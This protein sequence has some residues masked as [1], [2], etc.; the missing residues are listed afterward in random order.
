MSI[1]R[2]SLLGLGGAALVT[3]LLGMKY[4]GG[5]KPN[6][7]V[8]N[9][10]FMVADGMAIQSLTIADQFQDRVYGK[11]GYWHSLMNEEYATSGL[12]MT[13]SLS[14]VVTDSSAA[15]SAW[16]SGR[17]IWNGQVNQFPDGT[18]L[19]P[20]CE[21]MHSAGLKTGLVTTTRITHATPAGF[22][23]SVFQR[24]QEDDIALQYLNSGVDV[25]LGGGSRHFD[26]RTRKDGM[27]LAGKFKA[28]GF[29]VVAEKDLMKKSRSKKILGLFTSSHLPYTV[30][31]INNEELKLNVP[32][33]AE[34]TSHAISTL[35]GSPK[36]FLLQVEGGRVDHAG[37]ANDIGGMLHDQ[38]AFEDAVKVAV[39]FALADG[40]TLVVITTDHATGGLSLNG[41]GNEYFDSSAGLESLKGVKASF[42][43]L[44]PRFG[45][46]P[47]AKQVAELVEEKMGYR[48]SGK[49]AVAVSETWAGRSPFALSEFYNWKEGSLAVIMANHHKVG[50]TS[51]NHTSDHCLVTAIGPGSEWFRGV[52]WNISY[53]DY[54][55]SLKGLKHSNPTMSFEDAKKAMDN[56]KNSGLFTF[57]D[58]CC[59]A[60][61]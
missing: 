21:I 36:G 19:T 11:R 1:S 51:G 29:D 60:D 27:D 18:K 25:F 7:P 42:E 13:S 37:H 2:R 17:H 24:D 54:L 49:E 23:S 45:L 59:D 33:L 34:M 40:E 20:I 50:F 61:A 10:I 38:I 39:D 6:R 14:S 43:N 46:K 26:S 48:L 52:K 22:A 3:P 9:I 16:S 44:V 32:T 15:S 47:T 8:K 12:Q 53:F 30:D 31:H 4:E 57:C 41:A 56:A 28:A 55:L 58:H 35:K 5:S